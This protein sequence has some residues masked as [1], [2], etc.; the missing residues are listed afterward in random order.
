MQRNRA[1]R[2]IRAA[3]QRIDW[4]PEVDVVIVARRG[5]AQSGLAEVETELTRLAAELD[6][7]REAM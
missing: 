4:V 2:L 7:S 3:A 6:V 5:C 1:K